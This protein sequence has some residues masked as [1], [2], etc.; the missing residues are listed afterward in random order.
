MFRSGSTDRAPLLCSID[1]IP[2]FGADRRS[3]YGRF[4]VLFSLF[5]VLMFFGAGTLAVR[6]GRS[7]PLYLEQEQS[8]PCVPWMVWIYLS[9]FALWALPWIHLDARQI[10]ALSRQV[11][12]ATAAAGVCFLLLPGKLGYPSITYP[13]FGGTIIAALNELASASGYNLVPSLH[14]AYGTVV[15]TSCMRIVSPPLSWLYGAWLMMLSASTVL[16]HQHH[17]L[18]VAAGFILAITVRWLS[19]GQASASGSRIAACPMTDRS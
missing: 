15:L 10:G 9:A 18:D 14:V 5:F 6:I 8:I 17:L 16:T 7:L 19:L 13:G 11:N 2:R 12:T 3:A 4:V 1:P